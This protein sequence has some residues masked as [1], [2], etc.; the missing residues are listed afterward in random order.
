MQGRIGDSD[1]IG[2]KWSPPMI[3]FGGSVSQADCD[4]KK[5]VSAYDS[6]EL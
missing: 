6:F 2:K 3:F 1:V 4:R 5:V